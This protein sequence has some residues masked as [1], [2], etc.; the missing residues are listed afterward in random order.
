MR[1]LAY[2]IE[3][4]KGLELG[5]EDIE[6]RDIGF[7]RRRGWSKSRAGEGRSLL[8]WNLLR[9]SARVAADA[10]WSRVPFVVGAFDV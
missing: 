1:T 8:V 5:F 9:S 6:E 4:V 3:S 2:S 10:P 7:E